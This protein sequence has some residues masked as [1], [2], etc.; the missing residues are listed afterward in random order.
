MKNLLILLLSFICVTIYG[1]DDNRKLVQNKFAIKPIVFSLQAQALAYIAQSASTNEEL[2]AVMAE[3]L[4]KKLVLLREAIARFLKKPSIWDEVI[5]PIG[6]LLVQDILLVQALLICTKHLKEEKIIEYIMQNAS[7]TGA[8][9]TIIFLH[10][11]GIPID[12]HLNGEGRTALLYIA[13]ISGTVR[14]DVLI[15]LAQILLANGANVN[16]RDNC[17][18]TPLL[19]AARHA[20]VELVDYLLKNGADIN[21]KTLIKDTILHTIIY[22]LA[23]GRYHG[24]DYGHKE[25]PLNATVKLL[26]QHGADFYADMMLECRILTPLQCLEKIAQKK[27]KSAAIAKNLI[28]LINE[29]QAE[30]HEHGYKE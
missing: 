24:Y 6:K 19:F 30:V 14:S 10:T 12:M 7:S 8:V 11:N 2:K 9:E 4:F 22:D 1:M 28:N 25:S 29:R 13:S 17:G 23:G 3:D 21:A 27:D 18:R 16:A 5:D 26:L 15:R 20:R